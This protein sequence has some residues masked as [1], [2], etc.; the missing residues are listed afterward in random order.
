MSQFL[1]KVYK[2]LKSPLYLCDY[3]LSILR[4]YY[5]KF[6][7]S[8]ILNKAVF[9]KKFR[10]QGAL[11]ISG[12]GKVIIGDK[13]LIN[14][15]GHPVTP[16]TQHKDAVIKI[17]S[18]SVVSGTRFGCQTAI[19]IGEYALVGESRIMDT[20][21]HSIYPDRWSPDA[22]IES[23]PIMIGKNV[24]ITGG[25]AVLK[26]VHIGDNSVVGFGAVLSKTIPSN[27]VAAGN[28]AT[29]IKQI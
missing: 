14:G 7:Y 21:F 24:W 5:Y 25:G 22:V 27:C 20:D 16:F 11:K 28:P 12:P 10:V 23:S 6:K 26:G 3:V 9:G 8:I 29:V 1:N 13:V 17:G 19:T 18:N 4:G 2:G 15:L